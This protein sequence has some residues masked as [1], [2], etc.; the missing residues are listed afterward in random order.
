MLV[1]G[2]GLVCIAERHVPSGITALLL[3][4]KPVFVL[5]GGWGVGGP[6]PGAAA[7]LGMVAGVGGVALLMRQQADAATPWWAWLCILIASPGPRA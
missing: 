5:L 7:V 2:N 4:I 3:A 1:L 6:R